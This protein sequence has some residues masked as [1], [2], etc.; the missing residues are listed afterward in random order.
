[1]LGYIFYRDIFE[2]II[3]NFDASFYT[4]VVFLSRMN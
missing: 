2:F 1:M 4:Y 3:L